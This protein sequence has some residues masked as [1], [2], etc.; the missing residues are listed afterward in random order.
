MEAYT[1]K[2][3]IE[4]IHQEEVLYITNLTIEGIFS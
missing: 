4:Q 3:T 1:N 2:Q